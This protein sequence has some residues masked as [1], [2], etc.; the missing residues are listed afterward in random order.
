MRR[1]EFKYARCQYE[2]ASGREKKS[3]RTYVLVVAN[4]CKQFAH[5]SGRQTHLLPGQFILC[6]CG[7][8][9]IVTIACSVIFLIIVIVIVIIRTIVGLALSRLLLTDSVCSAYYSPSGNC[10]TCFF[11]LRRSHTAALACRDGGR[12]GSRFALGCACEGGCGTQR[13][14]DLKYFR[15]S[16]FDSERVSFR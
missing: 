4:V 6:H 1:L 2:S 11:P 5:F 3:M 12:G 9:C 14:L 16:L 7:S 10:L 8:L 15:V 13:L